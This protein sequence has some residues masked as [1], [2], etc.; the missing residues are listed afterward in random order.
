MLKHEIIN[1]GIDKGKKQFILGGGYTPND[2]IFK[3]KQSFEPENCT[4]F[5]VGKSIIDQKWYQKLVNERIASDPY[6][7]TS[8]NF[9]PLYRL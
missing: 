2:G 1:W 9:F 8:S 5:Y 6:F 7:D 4:P 3:Y